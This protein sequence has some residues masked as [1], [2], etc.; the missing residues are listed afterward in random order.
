MNKDN[1]IPIKTTKS[2]DDE[3]PRNSDNSRIRKGVYVK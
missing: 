3:L 1:T 2:D